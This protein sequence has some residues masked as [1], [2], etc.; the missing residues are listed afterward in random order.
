VISRTSAVGSLR[1][2][3]VLAALTTA[4][5]PALG[6]DVSGAGVSALG[7]DVGELMRLVPKGAATYTL[8]DDTRP[9]LAVPRETRL[10]LIVPAGLAERYTFAVPAD[11]PVGDVVASGSYA[12]GKRSYPLPAQVVTVVADA[13][14]TRSGTMVLPVLARGDGPPTTLALTLTA[15]PPADVVE[16]RVALAT[17]P[18]GAVL[19][20][21]Y[22]LTDAAGLR[23]AGPVTL[24]VATADRILWSTPLDRA[25][26][27]ARRWTESSVALSEGR[28]G[29]LIFRARAGA[30]G[31]GARGALGGDPPVTP[32]AKSAPRRRDVIVSTRDT[33]PADHIGTY[34]AYRPTTPA[35]DALAAESV[36]FEQ[37]WSVWP[38]TSGSH[39]SIFTSRFPSE[40]GVTSFIMAPAASTE[41]LAERLR[42]ERY[43]TRAF[44][45][46]GGVWAN[47]GFARG[48]S[49]YGERRSADFVYR[50]EAAA[51]FADATRWVESHRDRTFFLFVHTYQVHDPYNPPKTHRMLFGDIPG[52]E[53]VG[54]VA[55]A[56]N[57]D[58]EVRFTDE[59]VGLFV[60][61]IR[62]LGLAERTILVLLSDHGEEFGEH[63]GMGHG[64]TLHREL[65]HVPLIVWAPGLLAPA[66]RA[67]PVSMLDVAPTVLDLVGVAPDRGHRGVSLAA[68][69]RGA[70][71]DAGRA[72]FG[73]VDRADATRHDHVRAVSL[74]ANGQTIITDR[75]AGVTRCYGADDPG[76]QRPLA[77]CGALAATLARRIAAMPTNAAAQ[78]APADPRTVEKMRALGYVE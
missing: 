77:E 23:G 14:G 70:R 45:A 36:V 2:V 64:R 6:A 38:E 39:M 33:L 18:R 63:G 76:E 28:S 60:A 56:L 68:I 65:L 61:A 73:E 43:L 10:Q 21:A 41:L 59:Q 8:A 19:H 49:A 52:R 62:R 22:G 1:F 25:R 15:A 11:V 72:I 37:A 54:F 26:P 58:R 50:G 71:G 34:G 9:V 47:A 16:E 78:T 69:A 3:L 55:N 42:R 17:V 46:D 35:I 12:R 44:T 27:E 48:F 51:T 13:I 20:F 67:A 30:G 32:P 57:Y 29:A 66:R 24:E 7:A 5:V 4:G 53:G 75:I 40:H 31:R 74:R